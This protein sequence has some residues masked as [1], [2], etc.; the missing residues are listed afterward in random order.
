MEPELISKKELLELTGISYGQLYRWKRKKLIP[1][2]WFIRK[3]T[4]TGQETFFPKEK[5]LA[6]IEKIKELKDELSLDELAGVFA[7][8]PAAVVLTKE[9]IVKRHIVS[10]LVL[11]WLDDEWGGRQDVSFAELLSLYIVDRLL[12]SGEISIEEGKN[13]WMMFRS[14]Y[15]KLQGKSCELVV[16]RKMGVTVS[17]L[18]E[19]TAALHVE[20]GAKLIARLHVP[21]YIEELKLAISEG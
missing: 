17:F 11:Q 21:T 20:E 2:E 13:I 15:P 10:N 9:E 14:H 16:L 4:F 18:V 3:S 6:R 12:R 8:N 1:E 7:P 5:I 19:G